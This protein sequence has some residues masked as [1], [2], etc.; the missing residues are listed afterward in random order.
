MGL[1]K[2]ESLR[3]LKAEVHNNEDKYNG[4]VEERAKKF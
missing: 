1:Y 2:N 3:D 4:P